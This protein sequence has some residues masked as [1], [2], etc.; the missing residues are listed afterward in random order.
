MYAWA[1][2][3]W[4]TT[5]S[6]VLIGPWLLSLATRHRPGSATLFRVAGISIRAE[7]LPSLVVTLAALAQLVVLPSVGSASDRLGSRRRWLSWACVVGSVCAVALAATSGTRYV[8]AAGL[9]LLGSLAYGAS[10]VLYN[11]FLPQIADATER[12]AL[13]SRGFAY[14]YAGGGLL[15]AANL[16]LLVAHNAVGIEKVTAVRICFVSAGLW[17]AGFGLWSVRRLGP[18]TGTGNGAGRGTID[19]ARLILGLP[20]TRRYLLAYLLFSDAISAVIGLSS[21]FITHELFGGSAS[22]ASTFLF[23]LI[24]LIQVIALAGAV[25]FGTL[26]SRVGTKRAL[27]GSLAIWCGVVLY[28]Y[29]GVH[30]KEEAVAAGV[31]IG[32]VLGGSQALARSVWSQLVPAGREAAFFGI[33]EVANG[34]TAWVAPL[35]FTVVVNET[36]SYREAILS[37]VVLLVLGAAV[38]LVTDLDAAVRDRAQPAYFAMCLKWCVTER[39]AL[40]LL[41]FTVIFP[42]VN[43]PTTSCRNRFPVIVMDTLPASPR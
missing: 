39:K 43:T 26:A 14:G 35:L 1:N 13:S 37:L 25:V 5:V 36:G 32:I 16:L 19:T 27:L 8:V 7:S 38:L 9:Y 18:G 11:S 12:D 22:R 17:W 24:L 34:G 28:A 29:A 4:E 40:V 41:P 33:F 15:L 2:H 3:G 30:S 31:V 6:T 21:T 23:A 42:A 20:H 10:N